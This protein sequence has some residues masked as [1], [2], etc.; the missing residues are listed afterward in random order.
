MSEKV[1][2]SEQV[3]ELIAEATRLTKKDVKNVFRVL[4]QLIEEGLEGKYDRAALPG[5]GALVVERKESRNAINPKTK[6]KVKVP[7]KKVVKCRLKKSISV[8]ILKK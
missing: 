3:V 5:I 2:S 8:K 4:K 7:P 6:E 1:L